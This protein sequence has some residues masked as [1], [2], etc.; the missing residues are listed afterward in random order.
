MKKLKVGIIGS[1]NIGCD[2]LVKIQRSEYLECSL[3][4]GRN[5][6]SKGMQFAQSKGVK[7]TDKSI[8]ALVKNPELCDIVFDATTASSHKIHAPILKKMNKFTLD[9]TPS[10]IGKMCIPTINGEE[11]LNESNINM[12]TCGGQATVPIAKVISDIHPDVEYFEIVASIASKSAGK[13]TR[14]NID[15]FTQTTKDALMKF[16]GAKSARALII[17]NPAEPPIL[18]NNTIYATLKN[19]KIDELTQKIKETEKKLKKYVPGYS[20]K[21][22]PI[23]ENGVLTVM[24]QVIGLGD[25][26]PEYSGNLD[27]ITCSS[28]A[29]AEMYARKQ[30]GELGQLG[31]LG[32]QG[33]LGILE[34]KLS[35]ALR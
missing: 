23:Y 31:K 5:L 24:I 14:D 26:L 28:V 20:V 12:V 29:M 18:M 7:I 4:M 34:S 21:L 1:G 22:G 35:E 33:Q 10:L 27:I 16:T 17:V 32:Q 6:D 8:D 19:P 9:L 25:Y 30:L 11:C 13:G 15:E 2:L 3:L